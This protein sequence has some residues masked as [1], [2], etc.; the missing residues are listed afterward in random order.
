[1]YYQYETLEDVEQKIGLGEVISGFTMKEAPR[2]MF[3]TYI[4]NRQGGFMSIIE[5]QRLN[6][7]HSKKFVRL[8]YVIFFLRNE[9]SVIM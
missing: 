5:V 2:R 8:A 7:G 4:K 9:Q 3:F 1:M 6:Q